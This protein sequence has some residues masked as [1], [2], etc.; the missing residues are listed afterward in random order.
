MDEYTVE[1]TIHTYVTIQVTDD[2]DANRVC[3][4]AEQQVAEG[5]QS[6]RNVANTEVVDSEIQSSTSISREDYLA[7]EIYEER[8]LRIKGTEEIPC[9]QSR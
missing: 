2:T 4:I 5:M 1:V 9:T 3:E 8:R 6:L 7:D